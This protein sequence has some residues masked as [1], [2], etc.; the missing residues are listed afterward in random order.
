MILIVAWNFIGFSRAS[1]HAVLRRKAEDYSFHNFF[2]N[3]TIFL[4]FIPLHF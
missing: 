4:H 1:S 3:F 2:P